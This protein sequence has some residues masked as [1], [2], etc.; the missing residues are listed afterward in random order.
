VP[1]CACVRR[2]APCPAC[3]SPFAPGA[4]RRRAWRSP[5]CCS[6]PVRP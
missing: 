6:S 2:E 3:A 1:G 4:R 5:A